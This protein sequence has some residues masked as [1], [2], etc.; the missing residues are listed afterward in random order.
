MWVLLTFVE[1]ITLLTFYYNY[2][3]FT[4]ASCGLLHVSARKIEHY[5]SHSTL[6]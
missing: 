5:K 3:D 1:Y 2:I 4:D 6:K